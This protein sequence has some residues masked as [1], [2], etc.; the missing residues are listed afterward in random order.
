MVKCRSLSLFEGDCSSW[1]DRQA[2][3]QPV[4]VIFP[5]QDRFTVYQTN[6]SL[7]AGTH[8]QSASITL[9]FIYSYH[10]SDH[11]DSIVLLC[12]LWYHVLTY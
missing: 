4:T 7:L 11:V 6:C 2:I 12:R 5:K 3:A 10:L 1:A 9:L 8:A